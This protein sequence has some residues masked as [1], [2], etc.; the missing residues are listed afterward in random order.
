MKSQ[1]TSDGYG[2]DEGMLAVAPHSTSRPSSRS[3]SSSKRRSQ[4]EDDDQITKEES[5]V[6]TTAT[7][8][9]KENF[10]NEETTMADEMNVPGE[11]HMG[12]IDKSETDEDDDDPEEV[13]AAW[14]NYFSRFIA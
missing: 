14:I 5:A 9:A 8:G 7:D 13:S 6:T 12:H 11:G 1:L 10:S 2:G 4:Q 3:G